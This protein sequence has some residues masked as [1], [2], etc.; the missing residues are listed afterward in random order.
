MQ[1]FAAFVAIVGAILGAIL[2]VF[3]IAEHVKKRR[4]VESPLAREIAFWIVWGILFFFV[5]IALHESGVKWLGY[6]IAAIGMGIA[7]LRKHIRE[8]AYTQ[9]LEERFQ[10]SISHAETVER[11][12]SRSASEPK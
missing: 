6:L 7:L 9:L 8:D 12:E 5:P 2:A 10:Q 11:D 4:L 1:T 3:Q